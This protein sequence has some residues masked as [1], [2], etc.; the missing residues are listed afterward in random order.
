MEKETKT[1][2]ELAIALYEQLTGKNAVI[3]YEFDQFTLKV[4]SAV[5]SN[6]H[7]TWEMNGTL[8][9]STEEK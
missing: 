2:P 7:A 3:S 6:D 1:W 8:K 4:P 5:G 9:I